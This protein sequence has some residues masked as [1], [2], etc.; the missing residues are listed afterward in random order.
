M[1]LRSPRARILPGCVIDT[2][3][4]RKTP[5]LQHCELSSGLPFN[6]CPSVSPASNQ[7]LRQAVAVPH[8]PLGP[9][10]L[11]GVL[12]VYFTSDGRLKLAYGPRIMPQILGPSEREPSSISDLP[13][14]N[15]NTSY[16]LV[17]VPEIPPRWHPSGIPVDLHRLH[18][19]QIRLSLVSSTLIEY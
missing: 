19:T 6:D 10:T 11:F 1:A 18:L 3:Q 9:F 15:C 16:S 13:G 2:M 5:C 4:L 12:G 14:W 7:E 17:L 8:S